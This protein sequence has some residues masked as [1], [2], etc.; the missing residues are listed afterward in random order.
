MRKQRPASNSF[1]KA[2]QEL[3]AAIDADDVEMFEN[4]LDKNE[5]FGLT[6][7][8]RELIDYHNSKTL[9]HE[10]LE[11]DKRVIANYIAEKCSISYLLDDYPD[12]IRRESRRKLRSTFAN[13]RKT[14]LHLMV[15]KGNKKV[16]ELVMSRLKKAC[17]IVDDNLNTSWPKLPSFGFCKTQKDLEVF[18][19]ASVTF[20]TKDR[21]RRTGTA[22]HLAV[23]SGQWQT[24]EILTSHGL[25]V[26]DRDSEQETPLMLAVLQVLAFV[27]NF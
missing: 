25:S 15:E 4:I 26:N 14:C 5:K 16:L 27:L 22:I 21:R 17:T 6:L 7:E 19:R 23:V 2:R 13:R 8:S 20:D 9:F 11:K 24:L 12:V 1:A 10:A 18:L 3:S